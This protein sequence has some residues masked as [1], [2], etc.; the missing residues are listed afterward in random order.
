MES[1]GDLASAR[2]CWCITNEIHA[3]LGLR[4]WLGWN[5]I[6]IDGISSTWGFTDFISLTSLL[7]DFT[8][9]HS[10]G[11]GEAGDKEA[12]SS[13]YLCPLQEQEDV[14]VVKVREEILLRQEH[15]FWG[16]SN[17][18]LVSLT[19]LQALRVWH[20]P[21]TLLRTP[22]LLHSQLVL[23]EWTAFGS[24][25]SLSVFQLPIR[26]EAKSVR[27]MGLIS[28][29]ELREEEALGPQGPAIS[30]I[31]AFININ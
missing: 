17:T 10:G 18:Q 25:Q 21:G 16:S 28:P 12:L 29:Q 9:K 27:Q 30:L 31:H 26:V 20:C 24:H 22:C 19:G 14:L 15:V 11:S 2:A 3:E 1:P 8:L 6:T 13:T 7:R 5:W 4:Q 23:D